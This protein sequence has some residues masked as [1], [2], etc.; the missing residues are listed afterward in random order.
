MICIFPVIALKKSFCLLIWQ[1]IEARKTG[2]Q[3]YFQWIISNEPH[4]EL[5]LELL[6]IPIIPHSNLPEL[7]SVE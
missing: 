2:L 4:C 1:V 3:N 5:L 7:Q 6:K